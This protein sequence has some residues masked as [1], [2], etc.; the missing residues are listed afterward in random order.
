[1]TVTIQ[2]FVNFK[3]HLNPFPIIEIE[4]FLSKEESLEIFKILNDAKYDEKVMGNRR[5]IRKGTEEFNSIIK[6]NKI[7]NNLYNFFNNQSQFEFL[8]NKLESISSEKEIKKKYKIL[9]ISND[10]NQ[11]FY[12]KKSS[13][14]NLSKFER[15]Y[16]Y[17][18]KLFPYFFSKFFNFN[19]LDFVL[20]EAGK[21]YKL[22]THKDK[23]SRIIV[24]LLYLNDL[25]VSDGGSLEVYNSNEKNEPADLCKKFL[26]KAGKLVV[27]LSNPV[28]YHNVEEIKNPSVTRKFIY[29]SYSSNNDLNWSQ[30]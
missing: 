27:F 6:N 29:G 30:F 17:F 14:H 2:R 25:D 19:Y 1:M 9:N 7:L 8:L 21:G 13:V 18:N 10:F 23:P 22:Q 16:N 3:K 26:P 20:S 15:V 28:S 12:A 5:N 24:F 11:N 4:H